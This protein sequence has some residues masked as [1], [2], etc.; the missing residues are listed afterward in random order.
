MERAVKRF[1][2]SETIPFLSWDVWHVIVSHLDNPLDIVRVAS[3]CKTLRGRFHEHPLIKKWRAFTPEDGILTAVSNGILEMVNL[4]IIKGAQNVSRAF[5]CAS[6]AGDCQIVKR[7][8]E[9]EVDEDEYEC[10]CYGAIYGGHLDV[11]KL[12]VEQKS[13]HESHWHREHF[14]YNSAMRGHKHL[15]DYF[16]EK[17]AH[18]WSF[19]LIGAYFGKNE[20]MIA[21]FQE[22]I[23]SNGRGL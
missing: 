5:Y 10:V 18:N 3:T 22:K 4:Y 12:I 19:A 17:G 15:L 7:F 8:L 11:V 9:T 13:F 23:R 1:K 20:E 14:L 6:L 21:F 2:Q 16:I